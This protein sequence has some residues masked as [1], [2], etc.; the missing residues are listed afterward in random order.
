M[1]LAKLTLL[2]SRQSAQP[3]FHL[4]G[5]A[6]ELDQRCIRRLPDR[7]GRCSDWRSRMP[8]FWCSRF[9]SDRVSRN[10]PESKTTDMASCRITSVRCGSEARSRLAILAPRRDS[11]GCACED[12]HA[13]A[14]L[15]TDSRQQR[16]QEREPQHRPRR[17]G[18]QGHIVRFRVSESQNSV[19]AE[20]RD[21]QRLPHLRPRSAEGFRSGSGG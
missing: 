8:K 12:A 11:A 6:R 17:M 2:N 7:S 1:Y 20:P 15:N 18:L 10:V 5:K 9:I 21:T 16:H 3:F 13:G 19:S 14:V 4:R